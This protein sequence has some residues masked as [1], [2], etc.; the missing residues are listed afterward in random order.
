V[1]VHRLRI[2]DE[3]INYCDDGTCSAAVDTGTSLLAV[4]SSVF[5]EVYEGLRHYAP[6]AGH[7]AGPGPLLHLELDHFT[8]T[9]G[10]KD[11]A[12]LDDAKSRPM[13]RMYS[14]GTISDFQTKDV[15]KDKRCVPTLMTLD[16]PRPLGPKL[17][18]LGEPV[19]RKYYT[20][21][22]AHTKSVGFGRAKHKHSLS[23][24][25]LLISA[26]EVDGAFARNHRRPT[27][28]DIFR[29]R[30]ALH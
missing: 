18:I 20:V 8:V 27:M 10:P 19:L 25:D 7:C 3:V 21:F 2:D 13:P 30:R 29:W 23:R 24:E 14:D 1:P 26:G 11:Y 17:F 5:S 15:R 4:P 16:L 6:L 22:D 12:R 28:F 9:L